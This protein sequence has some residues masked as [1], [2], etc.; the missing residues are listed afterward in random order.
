MAVAKFASAI[1][2][3]TA[4]ITTTVA[5]AG[6]AAM[7]AWLCLRGW[8]QHGIGNSRFTLYRNNGWRNPGD[9]APKR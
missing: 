6:M 1:A 9:G 2:T 5:A 8:I 3:G 7:F 4:H